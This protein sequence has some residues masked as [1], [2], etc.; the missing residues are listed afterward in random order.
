MIT[1]KE[2]NP[3]NHELTAEQEIELE[4]LYQAI[5]IIRSSYGKALI[6]TSGFRTVEEQAKINPKAP[7]SKHTRAQ[8][9]DI[10]DP[11]QELQKWILENLS[12]LESAG[13]WCEDFAHTTNWIH[14]QIVPPKSKKRF[15]IP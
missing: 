5:N 13:L 12:I 7:N 9:V 6:V 14:F 10:Y 15:F 4:K 3:K 11:K 1:K 2:L 8:A